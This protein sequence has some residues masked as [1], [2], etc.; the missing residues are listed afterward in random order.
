MK[1]K[2]KCLFNLE[3]EVGEVFT[4]GGVK[5]KCVSI[6]T[7]IRR[8]RCCGCYYDDNDICPLYEPI[9]ESGHVDKVPVCDGLLRVRPS[10]T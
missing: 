2:F 7:K 3:P 6:N 8:Y 10:R 5:L 1:Y 4:I 9:K